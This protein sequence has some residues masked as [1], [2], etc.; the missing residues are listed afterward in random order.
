VNTPSNLATAIA[1]VAARN[2]DRLLSGYKL[3]VDDVFV[4][5]GPGRG[6]APVF[7][8]E[9]TFHGLPITTLDLTSVL[10]APGE[11]VLALQAMVRPLHTECCALMKAVSPGNLWSPSSSHASA[12]HGQP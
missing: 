3:Y 9:G 2:D 12:A 5:L 4:A 1:F 7:G 6:E 8:G 10:S 11:H